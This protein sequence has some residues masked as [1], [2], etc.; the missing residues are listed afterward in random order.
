MGRFK[1]P[2]RHWPQI[3]KEGLELLWTSSGGEIVDTRWWYPPC[4]QAPTI[5]TVVFATDG[6]EHKSD[7]EWRGRLAVASC[8]SNVISCHL[9]WRTQ[10]SR[11][12]G[13]SSK[14]ISHDWPWLS[15]I[16]LIV[17]P[18]PGQETG[19]PD[20]WENPLRQPGRIKQISW[21]LDVLY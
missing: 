11:R 17:P 7:E 20:T 12:W 19:P 15:L 14:R 18:Q 1:L 2:V 16:T 5:T 21:H 9:A 10:E 4:H 6:R 8:P 3:I 13:E